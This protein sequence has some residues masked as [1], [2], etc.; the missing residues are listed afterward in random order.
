MFISRKMKFQVESVRKIWPNEIW[1]FR[2]LLGILPWSYQ[3]KNPVGDNTF[4]NIKICQNMMLMI[5]TLCWRH[6]TFMMEFIWLPNSIKIFHLS[7]KSQSCHQHI[8]SP[9]S[10][11]NIDVTLS[12]IWPMTFRI[13]LGA[14]YLSKLMYLSPLIKKCRF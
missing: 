10:V 14:S 13:K 8:R 7:S 4:I 9:R 5:D 11:T 6:E 12:A 3:A 1:S 2:V